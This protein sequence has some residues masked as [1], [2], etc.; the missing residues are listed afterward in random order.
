M[1]YEKTIHLEEAGT[2]AKFI[3]PSERYKIFSLKVTGFINRED[4]EKVL[5]EMCTSEGE[6]EGDPEDD[7]WVTDIKHSPRLR[8]L[9][10]SESQ[11]V[12]DNTFPY[13][14]WYPL[15]EYFSFPQGIEYTSDKY[16][17]GFENATRLKTVVLPDGI[18][19]I[20]GF[21]GCEKLSNIN[22]PAS[23]EKIESLAFAYCRKL[24]AFPIPRKVR[25]I[26]GGAFAQCG[27]TSFQVDPDNPYFTTVDG[28]IFSK[29][30]KTLVAFPPAYPSNHYNIPEGTETIGTGAFED[31]NLDTIHIP[32]TVT[33]IEH[34]AFEYSGLRE[35]HIPDSVTEIGELCFRDSTNLESI[36]LPNN[37]S[38]L[39]DQIFS[40]CNNL[41][42]VDIPASVKK[43]DV[44]NIVWSESL[45]HIHLHNGLEEITGDGPCFSEPL[46]YKEFYLPKTLRCFPG[47]L[48][49]KCT[50]LKAFNLDPENPYMQYVDGAI[51]SKDMKKLLAVSDSRRKTFSI[52]DGVTEIGEFTFLGFSKLEEVTLPDSLERI[53][54]RTFNWCHSLKKIILPKN[55]KSI[56]FR[57]FDDC[58]SLKKIVCLAPKPPLLTESNSHWNFLIDCK[59]VTIEIPRA[60]LPL[61]Q[62]EEY[63]K[64]TKLIPI[65]D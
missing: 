65:K 33:K 28:V 52:K 64:K 51:Y 62:T 61:Y 17:S 50:N 39:E 54:H 12:G 11:F 40:G 6:F 44:T 13:M 48:F 5:D 24:T 37:I 34:W 21:S 60:S 42:E 3:P 47:W 18:K 43:M 49:Y 30:L 58:K 53:G 46:K 45:E 55:L 36:R 29:D 9:D 41:K 4:V 15:L 63:W 22:I 59:N 27:I 23:L 56:D 57:T 32:D 2:L 7:I 1:Q 26:G 10:L 35:V 20:D 25:Y 31:C 16:D 38:T 19:T 14:G 8:Y